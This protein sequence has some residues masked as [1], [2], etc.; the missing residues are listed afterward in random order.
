MFKCTNCG[1]DLVDGKSHTEPAKFRYTC[2]ESLSTD[3]ITQR[4]KLAAEKIYN[5]FDAV[6]ISQVEEL[7]AIIVEAMTKNETR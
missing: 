7:I 6:H 1:K 4:A 5:R 2:E 3:L